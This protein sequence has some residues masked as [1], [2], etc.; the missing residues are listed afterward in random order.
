ML[1][2]IAWAEHKHLC[3]RELLKSLG[4]STSVPLEIISSFSKLYLVFLSLVKNQISGN[5]IIRWSSSAHAQ[6]ASGGGHQD[7]VPHTS[8]VER[9]ARLSARQWGT[10]RQ[11]ELLDAEQ[12]RKD[13]FLYSSLELKRN[14]CSHTE[15]SVLVYLGT[16]EWLKR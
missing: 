7:M 10:L 11:E 16:W 5:I 12:P 6:A 8:R 13:I 2:G 15:K 14:M 3:Y 4:D 9:R 1:A